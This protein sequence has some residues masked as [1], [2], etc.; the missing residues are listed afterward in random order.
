MVFR[1]TSSSW[2]YS[3][4]HTISS[5]FT[6]RSLHRPPVY[7]VFSIS[8]IPVHEDGALRTCSPYEHH[9]SRRSGLHK[10][11]YGSWQCSYPGR[12]RYDVN[13]ISWSTAQWSYPSINQIDYLYAIQT[14]MNIA[15]SMRF[16]DYMTS[17]IAGNLALNI[18][19]SRNTVL[20]HHI[21]LIFWH[22]KIVM[23]L[24]IFHSTIYHSSTFHLHIVIILRCHNC[25]GQT[26]IRVR[27]TMLN[28]K[29]LLDVPIQIGKV[30]ESLNR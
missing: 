8:I 18:A 6:W 29:N 30:R 25:K 22:A 17:T 19:N 10:A 28:S 27:R 5:P 3:T 26:T 12:K 13:H 1:I 20:H 7:H 24:Q 14:E 9:S 2:L 16:L 21:H 15:M 11:L 4:L 23:I